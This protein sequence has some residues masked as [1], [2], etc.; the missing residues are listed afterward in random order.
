MAPASVFDKARRLLSCHPGSSI[1][2]EDA[3]KID[4]THYECRAM[5]TRCKREVYV[6]IT[7][8]EYRIMDNSEIWKDW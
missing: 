5:C 7:G 1:L 2:I 8:D 6:D 3:W 4:P